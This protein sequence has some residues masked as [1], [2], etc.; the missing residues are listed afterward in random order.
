MTS[1]YTIVDDPV[2]ASWFSDYLIFILGSFHIILSV[3][4][5]GEYFVREAPNILFRIPFFAQLL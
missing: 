1:N 3:W 4:M 2:V 5:V